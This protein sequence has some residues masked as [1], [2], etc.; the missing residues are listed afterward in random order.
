MFSVANLVIFIM[1]QLVITAMTFDLSVLELR[2]LDT[3]AIFRSHGEVI[4]G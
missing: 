4:S 3:V 1:S 2:D